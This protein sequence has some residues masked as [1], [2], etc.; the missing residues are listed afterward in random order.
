MGIV[1]TLAIAFVS[2][3][4]P[5]TS[6][7]KPKVISDHRVK[8]L[9]CLKVTADSV[10]RAMRPD[11][12]SAAHHLPYSNWSF[13]WGFEEL[14][15]CWSLS[16][17]QRLYFYLRE[18]GAAISMNEFSNQ[19]RSHE[20]RD[21]P[22]GWE[23]QPLDKYRPVPDQSDP[24]WV[25]WEKGWTEPGTVED[26]DRGLMPDIESYQILRFHQIQN[27]KYLTGP[28]ERTESE[29]S[30][31]WT[32]LKDLIANG[33]R[34]LLLLRPAR[35]N[36]HVVVAKR[37]DLTKTGAKIWVYD[38]NAPALERAVVWDQSALM[39]T[40]FDIVNGLQGVSDPTAPLGVFIVD[41]E[42]N[43][44]VLEA[45]AQHYTAICA[46]P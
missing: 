27:F 40:A 23:E 25:S 6:H 3:L 4:L 11:V 17:F 12:F 14:A 20:L 8:S 5:L 42:E 21:G 43:E 26:L 29:N 41:D 44:D 33:R 15:N 28:I 16:R 24:K 22:S 39:F 37:I 10:A 30:E 19:A 31:T 34:P 7:A 38:S 32:A 13:R 9:S 1:K 46:R 45:L 35:Y 36:Q 2:V 18:P